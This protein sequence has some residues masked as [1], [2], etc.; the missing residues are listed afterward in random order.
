LIVRP[1]LVAVDTA[2]LWCA[3]SLSGSKHQ[4]VP[5][6]SW[7]GEVTEQSS[8]PVHGTPRGRVQIH[9]DRHTPYQC[10]RV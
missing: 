2:G 4:C 3:V 5:S 9:S 1:Q 7:E 10:R 8:G 6:E